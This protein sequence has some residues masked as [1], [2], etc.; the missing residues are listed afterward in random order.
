MLSVR[1]C[2]GVRMC[3]GELA[4]VCFSP[5]DAA[6]YVGVTER[7]FGVHDGPQGCLLEF[8]CRQAPGGGS[9]ARHMAVD[10]DFL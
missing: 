9:A 10:D 2:V 1:L 6:L 8:H 4:G 7:L 5:D 3:A